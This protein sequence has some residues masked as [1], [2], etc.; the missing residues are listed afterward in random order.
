MWEDKFLINFNVEGRSLNTVAAF[1]K[2]KVTMYHANKQLDS[3]DN[4][5]MKKVVT[6]CGI[7]N[8]FAHFVKGTTN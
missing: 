6:I 1:S 7:N 5:T 2:F 4:I 8:Q 3:L